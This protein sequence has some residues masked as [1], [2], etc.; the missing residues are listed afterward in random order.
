M[1]RPILREAP[2]T[3]ARAPDRSIR[4]FVSAP[5]RPL[6]LASPDSLDLRQPPRFVGRLDRLDPVDELAQREEAVD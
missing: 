6:C 1:A 2:V 5:P 3:R 4:M